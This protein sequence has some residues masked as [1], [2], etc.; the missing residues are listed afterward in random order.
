MAKSGG[1]NLCEEKCWL[2]LDSGAV[3][4]VLSERRLFKQKDRGES[5]HYIKLKGITGDT[6]AERLDLKKENELG[7]K[8]AIL[9]EH[10]PVRGII[11]ITEIQRNGWQLVCMGNERHEDL[12]HAFMFNV[13]DGRRMDVNYKGGLMVVDDIFGDGTCLACDCVMEDEA[14]ELI[15]FSSPSK[16]IIHIKSGHMFCPKGF[17]RKTCPECMSGGTGRRGHHAKMRPQ[18]FENIPLKHLLGDFWGTIAP[19]SVRGNNIY[20]VVICDCIAFVWL[21]PLTSKSQIPEILS[22]LV[23]NIRTKYGKDLSDKVVWAVRLDNEITNRSSILKQKAEENR[24]L[25][26]HSAPYNPQQNGVV[27]RWMQVLG[28]FMRINLNRVDKRVHCYCGEYIADHW[29]NMK[30]EKYPRFR[31]GD[32]MSPAECLRKYFPKSFTTV[33]PLEKM[34]RFGCLCYY[35]IEPKP[36]KNEPR[37]QRAIFL[38]YGKETSEST[39][40]C[41]HYIFHK[42][43]GYQWC[44]HESNDVRFLDDVLV[45]DID[46]LKPGVKG[47]F[48][49][50]D[51]LDEMQKQ[52]GGRPPTVSSTTLEPD[53]VPS[54]D[55]PE[56][57]HQEQELEINRDDSP[58]SGGETPSIYQHD[59]TYEELLVEQQEQYS[60]SVGGKF[61]VYP[62]DQEEEEPKAKRGRGRP[63]GS[64]NKKKQKTN[65]WD[66]DVPVMIS[67]LEDVQK[68][69]IPWVLLAG[70]LDEKKMNYLRGE[71]DPSHRYGAWN[72]DGRL[73]HMEFEEG[74]TI[75][76]T[77]IQLG[78]SAALSSPEREKWIA[79][80][81]K[82]KARLCAYRTW[83]APLTSKELKEVRLKGLAI[84]PL[85]I[86]LTRKR[87]GTF[88]VS[89]FELLKMVRM[90]S[91]A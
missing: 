39:Y 34:K 74:E 69:T 57:E 61:V 64:K 83:G 76:E 22:M 40:R 66:D 29:N 58:R 7:L 80:I 71:E 27:E 4:T 78:V 47:L 56:Q 12:L 44:E 28:M 37:W 20:L 21:F 62:G 50:F 85:A 65:Q 8:S 13:R 84:V 17:D 55:N 15:L 77:W 89:N 35:C 88:K 31:Q 32:G 10:L 70:R 81:T 25:L 82:E 72:W 79:A 6:Y 18:K 91:D 60:N 38:G 63:K 9:H 14:G 87:D 67:W 75:E 68:E 73:K 52:D 46:D 53:Q 41:G 3:S 59:K 90:F 48:L 51:K 30:R 19:T 26:T 16:L 86:L 49:P 33:I 23:K 24:F 54:V 2:I 1:R 45:N 43:H 11:S 42:S 36:P 5:I